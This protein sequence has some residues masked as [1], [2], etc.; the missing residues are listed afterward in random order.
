MK[1]KLLATSLAAAMLLS[2][3]AGC[4]PQA[5]SNSKSS[6]AP[7][8]STA[9][10]EAAKEN[11]NKTGLPIVNEP[12]EITL[13]A[14]TRKNKNF[15]ELP[16]FVELEKKTNVNVNW[17]M[18]AKEGW[19]EK[20][21]LLFAGQNL[22]DAFY[23]FENLTDVEIVKYASQGMLIPLNDLIDQYAPNFK[24]V[25]DLN[26]TY[27]AQITAPDGNIYALPSLTQLSPT[28]HS[29]F[30]LN[31]T[32]L[33]KLSLPVPTTLEEFE[34]TL[35]AFNDNDMNGNGSK[36]DEI[37]FTFRAKDIRQQNLAP[38]FGSF[39]QLDDYTHFVIKDG[40]VIYTAMT[41]PYKDALK[42]FNGLYTKGLLD[43]EGFTHDQNVYVA[44]VQDPGK[45]CGGFLGW[46]RNSTGGPNKDDYI[47]IAPL[48]DATGK[49]VWKPVDSQI[50]SK[51]SFAI[52][53]AAANPEVLMRWID[54]SYEPET[55]LQ[56]DQGLLG[57]TIEKGADGRYSY[58]PVPE[59]KQLADLI[60]DG[61]PGTDGVSAVIKEISDKLNLNANLVE[62]AELDA[63]Y[64]PY[65]VP[66]DEVFPN[67]LFTMEEV[68][69]LSIL[70]TDIEA[71]VEKNYAGW[72][73]G[74]GIDAAWDGYM[75]KLKEMKVEEYIQIHQ[76]AYDRY[77]KAL[78]A[79]K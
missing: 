20:K 4:I 46:S 21:S 69:R 36:D 54:E 38:L 52:T 70:K 73:S 65:N 9:P 30:F 78:A 17:N 66:I 33:D 72:M 18:S 53:K 68:E 8:T 10:G 51:G 28:T 1:K 26:P 45:I 39:G 57:D 43:K 64:A 31:K 7:S 76:Q 27:K 48:K 32:W 79:V 77:A 15:K 5:T 14:I 3:M 56:I 24:H 55:S 63:F 58:L 13:A 41:D 50:T 60:H 75:A 16:Y 11:F 42:Y 19:P 29:K 6:S 44:K 12:V 47:A 37:P 35:Q 22:P 49:Q 61:G 59:G 71:Y 2:T 40:K 25:L 62:R 23:G 74:G 34:K 67:V